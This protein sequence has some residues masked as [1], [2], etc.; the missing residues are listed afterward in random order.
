MDRLPWW[1]ISQRSSRQRQA[2]LTHQ[3]F[4]WDL[5]YVH[6]SGTK[7]GSGMEGF[8]SAL[9]S[10]WTVPAEGLGW[11]R[12]VGRCPRH[13][14]PCLCWVQLLLKS[15]LP[16]WVFQDVSGPRPNLPGVKGQVRPLTPTCQVHKTSNGERERDEDCYRHR[17][18][19]EEER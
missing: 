6:R 13:D 9:L 16:I 19:W 17:Q 10:A 11:C 1:C 2:T 5:H 3:I 15:F 14:R 18:L 7:D 8:L 12:R 4:L